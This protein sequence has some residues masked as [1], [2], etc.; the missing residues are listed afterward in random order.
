MGLGTVVV[1]V[2]ST[3]ARALRFFEDQGFVL[4]SGYKEA[5]LDVWVHRLSRALD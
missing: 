2:F 4:E 3:N 5:S 1:D